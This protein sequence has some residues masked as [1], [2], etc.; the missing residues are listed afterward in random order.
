M[1]CSCPKEHS[2][3]QQTFFQV[4][5][6]GTRKPAPDPAVA[7]REARNGDSF[8][9]CFDRETVTVGLEALLIEVFRCHA[10]PEGFQIGVGV[11][12]DF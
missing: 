3:M 9:S 8:L 5:S 11:D 4:N 7:E 2:G 12:V 1:I 10:F 6:G